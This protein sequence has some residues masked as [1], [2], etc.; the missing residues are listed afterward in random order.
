MTPMT[1]RGFKAEMMREPVLRTTVNSVL[2]KLGRVPMGALDVLFR[3]GVGM[4]F[5]KSG[6]TKI[7]NWDITV[8]LFAEEYKVPVLSP[9]IAAYLGT[10]A[11]LTAPI[12]LF[13]GLATR[14]AAAALLGMTMVIQLFVY[15]ENWSEHLLWA[16]LL[17]YLVSRGPG[18]ISLDRVIWKFWS[19]RPI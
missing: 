7:A 13:L 15:P 17:L 18:P 5:W 14:P 6:M 19:R 11:E 2:E 16:S 1:A 10:A 12:L 9:E 4:V 3:I 8:M